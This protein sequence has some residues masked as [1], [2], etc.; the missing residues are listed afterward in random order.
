MNTPYRHV[1]KAHF[2]LKVIGA[3]C[4]NNARIRLERNLMGGDFRPVRP[5]Y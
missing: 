3:R 4:L 1:Y 5:P 2:Q